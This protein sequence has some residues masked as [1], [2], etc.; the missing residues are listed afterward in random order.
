MELRDGAYLRP[1]GPQDL[2]EIKGLLVERG[3]DA[4]A[5][6]FELVVGDPSAGWA[7]AAVVKC[8]GQVVATAT[9]LNETL[10]VGSVELPAG[11]VEMV[12]CDEAYEHRGYVRALMGWCHE[13]SAALGHVVQIMVGIPYF[14]RKFG[15]VY[16]IPMHPYAPLE[17]P[18]DA[19]NAVDE[20]VKVREALVGDIPDMAVLHELV[21]GQRDIAMPHSPSCWEWLLDRDGTTTYVATRGTDMVATARWTAPEDGSV[22]MS[23]VASRDERATA[24]LLHAAL[25]SGASEI[26]VHHRPGV[27]GLGALLGEPARADWYYVRIADQAALLSALR[28]ELEQRLNA[29]EF[30]DADRM[31]ELSFWESQLAFPIANGHV[32]PITSGGPRQIIVSQ[33]GSGLPPDALPHLVFGCGAAGIEDRFPDAFLGEQ[34]DLMLSLFPAMTADLLT[35]YLPS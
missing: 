27:P 17:M 25:S 24:T 16:A 2:A 9:L 6:D 3:E 35:F 5:I 14:Y 28:P 30:G 13:R 22:L 10:R 18:D 20:S 19:A 23:E 8:D 11:Q 32:G 26:S 34:R 4:D 1:A 7:C 31:V 15:Y 29:S 33:G 21:Q 12:A